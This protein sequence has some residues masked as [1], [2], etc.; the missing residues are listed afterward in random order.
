MGGIEAGAHGGQLSPVDARINLMAPT[1]DTLR[2]QWAGGAEL[3][4]LHE[5]HV[6]LCV[7]LLREHDPGCTSL[8]IQVDETE[9]TKHVGYESSVNRVWGLAG[10]N[11]P[12]ST[13][14]MLWFTQLR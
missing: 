8:L 6:D 13:F 12:G 1:G 5:E 14:F 3:P 4:G 7:R 10:Q 2:K 11:N 9:L